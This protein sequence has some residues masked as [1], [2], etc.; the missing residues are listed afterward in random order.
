MH[1][2]TDS[3][4]HTHAR[5]HIHTTTTTTTETFCRIPFT[6]SPPPE[7]EHSLPPSTSG[8]RE[9]VQESAAEP[10]VAAVNMKRTVAS[11]AVIYFQMSV[12]SYFTEANWPIAV[13]SHDLWHSDGC[14]TNAPDNTLVISLKYHLKQFLKFLHDEW[15]FQRELS[16]RIHYFLL[17]ILMP[18]YLSNS[19]MWPVMYVYVTCDTHVRDHDTVMNATLMHLLT[20][21]PVEMIREYLQV[22]HST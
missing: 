14:H 1:A 16:L 21:A 13:L 18:T 22:S 15:R 17:H 2:Y 7:T 3:V 4:T 11:S 10:P 8:E 9:A 6:S 19:C 20:S 5:T 12:S